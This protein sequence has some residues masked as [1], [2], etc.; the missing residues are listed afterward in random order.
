LSNSSFN[1]RR[2]GYSSFL[3]ISA[4]A[5]GVA[6]TG[7]AGVQAAARRQAE[8]AQRK[9][10]ARIIRRQREETREIRKELAISRAES[11]VRLW[12]IL[13]LLPASRAV[14]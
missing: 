10:V 14:R 9:R 13:R 6:S 8:I 4:I 2:F 11:A 3:G 1:P 12:H 7:V 5:G